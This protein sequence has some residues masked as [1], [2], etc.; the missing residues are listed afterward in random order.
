MSALLQLQDADVPVTTRLPELIHTPEGYH[1]REEQI[2]REELQS[3]RQ[4]Y[5]FQLTS[6]SAFMKG[7]CPIRAE[8]HRELFDELI[9]EVYLDQEE[10]GTLLAQVRDEAQMTVANYQTL[11]ETTVRQVQLQVGRAEEKFTQVKKPR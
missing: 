1:P 11:Y 6:R 5:E 4:Q 3:L 10:A 7:L 2:T 9:R 8:I